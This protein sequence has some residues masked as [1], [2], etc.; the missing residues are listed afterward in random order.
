MSHILC[1]I[2]LKCLEDYNTC[3][4]VKSNNSAEGDNSREERVR[5]N[6][7]MHYT[8]KYWEKA[9]KLNAF[10]NTL[11]LPGFYH[12]FQFKA[13]IINILEPKK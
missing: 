5:L 1:L 4:K 6:N 10:S 7:F 12:L 2:I 3:I 11:K 8:Y 9:A 13:L